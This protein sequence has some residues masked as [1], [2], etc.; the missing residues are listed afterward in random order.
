MSK[1]DGRMVLRNTC[2]VR[3]AR[4]SGRR[5]RRYQDRGRVGRGRRVD[6]VRLNSLMPAT[7]GAGAVGDV[8]LRAASAAITQAGSTPEVVGIGSAGPLDLAPGRSVRSTFLRGAAIRSS[9]AGREFPGRGSPGRRRALHGPGRVLATAH[10]CGPC[11]EW[12]CPPASGE[13]S[14]RRPGADRAD[15]E[16][17]HVG[18]MVVDIRGPA[19]PCGGRGC[20]EA[21][22]SGP[23]M[24][25]WARRTAGTRP[26][27]PA[28]SACRVRPAWATRSPPERS[29]ARPTR[30]P[31]GVC[32]AALVDL[33]DVVLGGGVVNGAGD[34]L[35]IRPRSGRRS[36]RTGV[37]PARADRGEQAGG[38]CRLLSAAALGFEGVAVGADRVAVA[39][40]W[41]STETTR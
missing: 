38:R 8:L 28:R 25:R 34:L 27:G 5:R 21:L 3:R 10:R 24:V 19:C 23:S 37:H 29:P 2:P 41:F 20:V 13:A 39:E 40:A 26:A 9:S 7:E 33:D 18:H 22:A 12:S 31:S 32:T 35:S 1:A 4:L 16:R 15:R 6:P 17:R 36:G 14:S 30:S 11:W